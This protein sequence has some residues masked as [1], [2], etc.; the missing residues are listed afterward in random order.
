M[1]YIKKIMTPYKILVTDDDD[2]I[3]SALNRAI[4]SWGF[5]PVAASTVDESIKLFNLH[6]PAIALVSLSLPDGSGFKVLREIKNLQPDAVVI[7]LTDEIRIDET[8]TA[9]RAGA[10]DFISKPVNLEALRITIDNIVQTR[11]LR[12]KA[13]QLPKEQVNSFSFENIIGESAAIKETIALARKV[14]ASNVSTVL[15]QGESGT[16]KDLVAKAI[17]YSSNREVSLLWR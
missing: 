1:A 2:Q 13:S 6:R 10:S 4:T 8:L 9:L 11:K 12:Q 14:S 7:M 3:R 5:V 17:H 16:G 15:L